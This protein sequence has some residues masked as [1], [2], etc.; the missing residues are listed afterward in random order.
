MDTIAPEKAG[1]SPERL[2]RLDALLQRYMDA[3]DLPG[4]T[5]LVARRGQVAY[6]KLLGMADIEAQRPTQADTI[7]RIYSMT[8]PITSFAVLM[9]HEEGR[10]FLDSPVAEFI[11]EFKNVRVY[12]EGSDPIAPERPITIRHLLTHTAG[13][14][15]GSPHSPVERMM[16]DAPLHGRDLPLPE[17]VKRLATLPLIHH[18]GTVWHYSPAVDVLGYLVKSCRECPLLT[19]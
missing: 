7:Y 13:L 4:I 18:P 2:T 12:V 9:L 17:W 8:K 16:R 1:F 3:G 6:S 10:F 15:Y 11:P 19:F 14:T 5:L